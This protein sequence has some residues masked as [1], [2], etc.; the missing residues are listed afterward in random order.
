M[1]LNELFTSHAKYVL[2]CLR[3]RHYE[4]REKA[5]C[6]LAA[7]LRQQEATLAIPAI[8][9]IEK[10]RVSPPVVTQSDI[11]EEE[12]VRDIC[13]IFDI[14]IDTL[15]EFCEGAV[16]SENKTQEARINNTKASKT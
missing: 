11:S 3:G 9:V 13:H 1:A 14:P 8:R 5:R 4:Q 2:Q 16:I 10:W 6:L 15:K 7:Q 12:R